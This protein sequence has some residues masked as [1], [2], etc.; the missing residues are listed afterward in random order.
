MLELCEQADVLIE[1]FRPGVTE[2]LGLGPSDVFA[3]NAE[4]RLWSHHRVRPRRAARCA[5]GTRHQ[6]HIGVG[7]ALADRARRRTARATAQPG[8]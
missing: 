2:R 3:R 5:R 6:L 7:R 4:A 8:R 1:G